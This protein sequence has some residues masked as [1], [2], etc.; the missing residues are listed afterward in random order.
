MKRT[1]YEDNIIPKFVIRVS[2]IT[3]DEDKFK[4]LVAQI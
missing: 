1:Y 3:R 4:H 2:C